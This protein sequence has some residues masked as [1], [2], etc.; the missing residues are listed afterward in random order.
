M[1]GGPASAQRAGAHFFFNA[2]LSHSPRGVSPLFLLLWVTWNRIT[3]QRAQTKL[4]GHSS[5]H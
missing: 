5:P 3:R 1:T 2:V 4:G